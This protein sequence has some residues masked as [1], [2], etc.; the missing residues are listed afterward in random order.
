MGGKIIKKQMLKAISF[1]Q[2]F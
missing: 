2:K 1:V